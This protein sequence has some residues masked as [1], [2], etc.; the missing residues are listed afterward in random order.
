MLVVADRWS[1]FV[2]DPATWEFAWVP[3][4]TV[5]K[6]AELAA[7]DLVIFFGPLSDGDRA[8]PLSGTVKLALEQGATVVFAYAARFESADE[9]FLS[10][11]VALRGAQLSGRVAP[12]AA[13]PAP[14]PALREYMV[15]HGHTDL[16]LFDLPEGAEV[17]AH[18]VQTTTPYQTAPTAARLSVGRGS[19]YVVP[20]HLT[21]D[22]LDLVDR[23]VHAI[24][25]HRE[26]RLVRTPS[27]FGEV[28][29]PGEV[30]LTS[31]I[32]TTKAELGRLEDERSELTEHK[33]LIGYLEGGALEAAVIDELN[34]VLDGSA[35]TARDVEELGAEDF[36]IWGA[37]R[38]AIA[39]SKAAAGGV[40]LGHVSQL[41]GHRTEHLDVSADELPGLLVV[42]VFRNDD[43]LERRRD[44]RVA[45]R[46][47]KQARRLNVLVLRS[48]DLFELIR[49]RLEGAD[50]SRELV[51]VLTN[52]GGWLE[53]GPGGPTLHTD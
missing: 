43:G 15:M 33:R 6:P 21:G 7:A 40:T 28:D 19:L 10:G 36:E 4:G 37:E 39:E 41:D 13:D 44:E 52:G 11:V 25:N 32:D 46:V 8:L 20:C 30:E 47:V 26:G 9:R 2:L 34:F 53:V 38:I 50:D 29:L 27:F 35:Y 48:W 14:H 42:N 16:R 1:N 45:Q 22:L 51:D 18:V 12:P 3:G 5:P 24:R 49:R 23:L 17:L 31:K